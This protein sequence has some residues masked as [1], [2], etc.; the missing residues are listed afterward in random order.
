MKKHN[1]TIIFALLLIVTILFI[2][3]DLV[4]AKE[5]KLIVKDADIS[6]NRVAIYTTFVPETIEINAGE[7]VTWVN[8]KRPKGPSVLVSDDELWEDTTL[9]YGKTFAYTFEK[10]G[11]YTFTLKES[12]EIKGTIK[13]YAPE[14]Q[15]KDLEKTSEAVT[16]KT[17]KVT[18]EASS[19]NSGKSNK[20]IDSKENIQNEEKMLIYSTTFS[21]E[22]IE[23]KKGNTITWINLKR[24][25]GPA[26]LVS[27]DGLWKDTTL[28]YGKAFSYTFEETG[29]Y[30]FSLET[31]PEAK[32]TVI[33]T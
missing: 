17:P 14:Q 2:S 3:T 20:N 22:T 26:V 30:T 9:Y 4:A 10:P 8:L 29:T 23:I 31:M 5:T 12:P 21:P 19:S 32:A 25:K 28:Y 13:V 7:N 11:T 24:P 27:D 15:K 6:A 1:K 16:V 33:V 18:G